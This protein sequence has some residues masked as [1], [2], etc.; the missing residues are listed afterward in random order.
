MRA[1]ASKSLWLRP[2]ILVLLS[3]PVLAAHYFTP[4]IEEYFA[5]HALYQRVLYIP[6]LLGAFW[7]GLRGG[8][9][10]SVAVSIGYFPHI[11]HDWG[12][13]LFS[14]NTNQLLEIVMYLMV[15]SLT[16]VLVDLLRR[17]GESLLRANEQL[18]AQSR[19]L[20]EYMTK[21]TQKTRELFDIEEQL[22]RSDR[23][24]AL[25]QLTAGL[26]H[27]IR[28]PLASIDGAVEILADPNID[29]AQR[30]KFGR[31][32]EEATARMNQVLANFLSYARSERDSAAGEGDL[33]SAVT[34]TLGLL[35]QAMHAQGIKTDAT[36]PE[37]DILVAIPQNLLE[38]ALLNLLLNAV[39]A[40]GQG[41]KIRI[42]GQLAENGGMAEISIADTGP[43]IPRDRLR[44]VFDPFFTTKPQ[45]TGLGLSIVH[46]ILSLHGGSIELDADYSGGA[47]FVLRLPLWAPKGV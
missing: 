7:Y 30:E 13:H 36:M 9:L 23:L 39:Q 38:Q 22:R 3:L 8:V 10:V 28:N 6:I 14:S 45:G 47:R 4:P 16:G 34:K 24:A 46:K 42:E 19:Q 27:E 37:Q 32:L 1:R 12:G 26:A 20:R 15:G 29:R 40:M 11:M 2:A 21:L 43:G 31:V 25:G 33:Q 17:R 35:E 18:E 44:H 41:G 5:F